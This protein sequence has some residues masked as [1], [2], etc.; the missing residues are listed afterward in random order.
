MARASRPCVTPGCGALVTAGSTRCS[1]C[2]RTYE[3]K[4]GSR[5][6]R[7]Y[8]AAHK[9]ERARWERRGVVGLTCPRCEQPILPGDDWDLDHTDDRRG[10]LG[11]SHARCNRAT[12]RRTPGG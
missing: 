10:Y 2:A 3:A 9:R 11:P 7:G 6:E 4:R 8:G 1:D 5:Q 12:A